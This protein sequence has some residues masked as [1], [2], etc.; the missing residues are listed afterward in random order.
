MISFQFVLLHLLV[1][2]VTFFSCKKIKNNS[3]RKYWHFAYLSIC[4][5]ALEEGLRW[6]RMVDWCMY[7]ETY[8]NILQTSDETME[9]VFR[10]VWTLFAI[11]NV[12]YWGVILF[13]ALFFIVSAF[14]FCKPYKNLLP[15][16]MPLFV[17]TAG[18][19]AENLIRWY[20]SYSFL[21]I[22]LRLYLDGK[23]KPAIGWALCS[24]LTHYAMILSVVLFV[25]LNHLKNKK[26]CSPICAICLSVIFVLLMSYYKD[27]M[28][29][30]LFIAN[31]FSGSE[32]FAMYSDDASEWF[33]V[34]NVD[35]FSNIILM[36]P[37]YLALWVANKKMKNMP[38]NNFFYNCFV[39]SLLIK[40]LGQNLELALR[41][42]AI[43][44]PFVCMLMGIVYYSVSSLKGK[45]LFCKAI[46]LLFLFMQAVRFCSPLEN[47]KL[48]M[49]VWNDT[50]PAYEL[51]GIHRGWWK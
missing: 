40:S 34:K 5:F 6:G 9:P 15:Y 28:M 13:M 20:M 41:Y 33:V 3:V 32:R 51:L 35:V 17:V 10:L 45:N 50:R 4:V 26:I 30:L 24:V 38:M 39:V 36:T 29:N 46:M 2:L 14:Y 43:F 25:A 49:Y 31:V 42:R 48:N 37:L 44:D 8:N 11:L 16:V 27:L 21:L 12:P 47:D 18:F 1:V 22:A 19:F 7:H 23:N